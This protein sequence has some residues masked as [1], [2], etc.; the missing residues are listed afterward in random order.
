MKKRIPLSTPTMHG[1]EIEY[2]NEAF[3]RNWVAPLGFNCDGFEKEMS[4]YL[5]DNSGEEY[6]ALSLVSGTS[7]LHLAVK[8]AGIKPGDIVLCSDMTFAATVNPVS[9]EFGKQVFI[10]SEYETWNMDPKALEKAFELSNNINELNEKLDE[11]Y[12][13]WEELNSEEI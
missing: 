9:Y 6:H 5:S 2:I 7:A 4:E 1:N 3:E 12:K 11:L 10:D 8:L 13:L